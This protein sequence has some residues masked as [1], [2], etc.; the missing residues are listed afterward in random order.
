MAVL[1]GY[2]V[3]TSAVITVRFIMF[4]D[5]ALSAEDRSRSITV[6]GEVRY[7]VFL[8]QEKSYR[9]GIQFMGLSADDRNF[10]A[11]FIKTKR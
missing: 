8:K 5:L 4:D 1:T 6:Q 3:P 2:A 7:N 11:N 9:L 10:I